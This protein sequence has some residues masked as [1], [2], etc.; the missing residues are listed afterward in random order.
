MLDNELK[1]EAD[2]DFIEYVHK[3]MAKHEITMNEALQ[4]KVVIEVYINMIG[5][6]EG[7]V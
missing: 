3:F 4:H 1:K 2:K 6:I 5:E 7:K